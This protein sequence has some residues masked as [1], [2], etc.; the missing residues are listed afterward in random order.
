[1]Q[2]TSSE[3]REIVGRASSI[4]ERLR[5]AFI[6]PAEGEDPSLVAGRLARWREV[7]SRDEPERFHRRLA[8]DR[9][10]QNALGQL[11]GPA[12]LAEDK[13]LP[14]WARTLDDLVRA[15]SSSPGYPR[16][17]TLDLP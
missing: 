17:G 15:A 7:L 6:V 5:P 10:E 8:W 1:M 2:F 3:L 14:G 11:L 9:L 12:L 16:S 4:L 13:P